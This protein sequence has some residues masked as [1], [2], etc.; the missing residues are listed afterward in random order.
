VSV[1]QRVLRERR[2][3]VIPLAVL[4]VAAV[5]TLALGVYPL[6]RHVAG[7]ADAAVDADLA[8]KLAVAD[9]RKAKDERASK[10]RAE[11]DLQKFYAEI[12]PR[13]LARASELTNYFLG[14]AATASG[15]RYSTGQFRPQ[16]PTD[17]KRSRLTKMTGQV[18]L[19]GDYSAIRRFLYHV[20]TA[21]EFVIVEDMNL[22]QPGDADTGKN[23]ELQLTVSSY[24]SG[25][26]A[27]VGRR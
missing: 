14:Q 3:V 15:L 17:E 1:W 4:L 27:G 6:Q 25:R 5:G 8:L 16:V 18:T 21:E 13:D 12:L 23:L 11:V 7:L 9:D 10:E 19:R 22:S 26:P 24:F 20:E 2:R